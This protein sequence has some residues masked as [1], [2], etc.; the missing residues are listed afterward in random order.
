MAIQRRRS[1]RRPPRGGGDDEALRR[2][3]SRDPINPLTTAPIGGGEPKPT[4]EEQGGTI[5]PGGRWIFDDQWNDW[6]LLSDYTGGGGGTPPPRP[7]PVT[8]PPPRPPP[9]TQVG[10]QRQFGDQGAGTGVVGDLRSQGVGIKTTGILPR[11]AIGDDNQGIEI[12]RFDGG[13]VDF[14]SSRNLQRNQSPDVQNMR[15]NRLTKVS[16]RKG[17]DNRT[18]ITSASQVTPGAGFI[19]FK[20]SWDDAGTPL[21]ASS[22]YRMSTH[23]DGS[24]S[25]TAAVKRNNSI[26]DD[27]GTFADVLTSEWTLR[28][29]AGSSDMSFASNTITVA[30]GGAVF[31][32]GEIIRV[33]GTA[34]NNGYYKVVS[35]T[36]TTIVVEET[37]TT[38]SNTSGVVTGVPIVS[39]YVVGGV[40]RISDGN[41]NDTAPSQWY[42]HIKRDFWGQGV[43]YESNAGRFKQPA[44]K[45]AYNA[46]KLEA[47]AL[48]APIMV[49]GARVGDVTGAANEVAI[50]IAGTH[51]TG[52]PEKSVDTVWNARDRVTC[53]FVYDFT[54]ESELGR[55]ANG[56]IGIEMG[57]IITEDDARAFMVEVYTGAS[58]AS[59]NR[60]I[61]AIK[62]YYNFHDDVD[63]YEVEHL[64]INNGWKGSEKIFNAK[65]TGYWIPIMS[66]ILDTGTTNGSGN[67]GTGFLD[68]A[69]SI[70]ANQII[71]IDN[72]ATIEPTSLITYAKTIT[73]SNNIVLPVAPVDSL[74]A[75]P[76]N[77][78]SADWC[79]G[80]PSTTAVATFYIPFTGEKAFTYNI[81]T[82]RSTK[83]K[84][85]A[86]KWRCAAS[87][88]ELVL[89]GNIDTTDENDQTLREHS[90]VIETKAGTPDVFPLNQSKDV[91]IEEGDEAVAIASMLDNWWVLKERNIHV[92]QK[93]TLAT[94]QVFPGVGCE[95]LHS[96]V[97][98]PYGL[99]V[100][101]R[102]GLILLPDAVEL[103]YPIRDTYQGLTFFNPTLGYSH[104]QKELYLIPDTS[105]NGTT[106]YTLDMVNQSWIQDTLPTNSTLS[107]FIAGRHREPEILLEIG[108][109]GPDI[110]VNGRLWTGATGLTPPT[111]YTSDLNAATSYTI[112]D[113]S[114]VTN[115]S[116]TTLVIVTG[117]NSTDRVLITSS[118]GGIATTSGQTYRFTFAYRLN[119]RLNPSS[120][121]NVALPKVGGGNYV[122]NIIVHDGLAGDAKLV[123]T[124]F[125]STGVTTNNYI[126]VG[127]GD[128]TDGAP[129]ASTL[130]IADLK[131]V[132]ISSFRVKQFNKT[133]NGSTGLYKTPDMLLGENPAKV[134][135]AYVS[136][137]S[138]S[139]A[140]TVKIYLDDA[141]TALEK[142]LAASST[143]VHRKRIQF[144]TTSKILAVSFESAATDFEVEDF[145]IPP[146][147]IT[148][149]E[150]SVY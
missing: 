94:V 32:P 63:W 18:A 106:M 66:S 70:L 53:T 31:L 127:S 43:T 34:S 35:S 55:T 54:Q 42:G 44:M 8:Q 89:I 97:V 49:A 19:Q 133:T 130:Q 67:T 50:H 141:S 134:R 145:E 116:T 100:A 142:Q 129:Y 24:G 114:G 21:H 74:G 15:V 122:Q 105:G 108:S 3:V 98:T 110:A 140:V 10:G 1:R 101:D 17:E 144:N 52:W 124:D 137:K 146:N 46:W 99:I 2:R 41:F 48:T 120:T 135:Y 88:G 14:F 30:S 58:N 40:V 37:L 27:T 79:S 119:Q 77:W 33:I 65:N 85:P 118:A 139:V 28:S 61:T 102:A 121:A 76:A 38:E 107:N 112:T 81:N 93:R 128:S 113:L 82:G 16:K 87:D 71:Y 147:E 126:L 59:W 12:N 80:D 109:Q 29:I 123:S 64:E 9:V 131:L 104:L 11:V 26:T 78:Q 68:T 47:Q 69:H 36:G 13:L 20:A 115:L 72:T 84:I 7:P 103:T 60:R 125:V 25:G 62:L 95:W 117:A 4:R 6:V 90:R 83:L 39:M 143:L 91:G 138:T 51:V 136:Y 22:H 150:A 23:I 5:S 96:F 149:I 148:P 45:E 57:T 86:T 132:Q 56:E 73:D 75:S 111:G 92:L